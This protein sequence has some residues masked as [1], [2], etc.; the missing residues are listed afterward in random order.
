[1]QP[2]FAAPLGRSEVDQWKSKDGRDIEGMLTYPAGLQGGARVPL[3]L[4]IHGGPAGVFVAQLHRRGLALP[5]RG[6]R[7]ARLRHAARQPARQQR[8]RRRSSARPTAADWGGGDYQDLMTGVDHVIA[9]GVADADRA[10]RDGLELRR[11][12]DV[13]G[14][15][16]DEAVQGGVGRRRRDAT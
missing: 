8:L 9:M 2:A 6:V 16:P 7:R 13:V 4:D 12:H 3:V 11:L 1:M 14:D 10:R 5:D 15:H